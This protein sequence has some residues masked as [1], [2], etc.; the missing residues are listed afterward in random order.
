MS[1][2]DVEQP[3]NILHRPRHR[4]G[5][6]TVEGQRDHARARG[7]PQRRADSH[8]RQMRARPA[9]RIAR[10]GT[11]TRHGEA[12]RDTGGRPAARSCRRPVQRVRVRRPS[13]RRG[14]R[15]AW[16]ERPLR[17]VRLRHD[18]RTRLPQP[19]DHERVARRDDA[20]QSDRAAGRGQI[21]RVEVV[22]DQNRYAEQPSRNRSGSQS[23]VDLVRSLQRP[24]IHLG[25]GVETAR[26]VVRIDAVEV[27][28]DHVTA[29]CPS[30]EDRR[31]ERCDRRF[32]DRDPAAAPGAR[33]I[34]GGRGRFGSLRLVLRLRPVPARADPQ[35]H[36]RQHDHQQYLPHRRP[37][38]SPAHLSAWNPNPAI[39]PRDS[40]DAHRG[41]PWRHVSPGGSVPPR[42]HV[43]G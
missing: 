15:L 24:R 17:H 36:E 6:V 26:P 35:Q 11:E 37:L 28:P 12:R 21:V 42:G 9:D 20:G 8:E 10:V 43:F 32:D 29:R 33:N 27:G 23:P 31:L 1:R 40:T 16:T 39:T 30:L 7:E 4:P 3:G 34:D 5:H 19:P 14:D 41:A 22:L 2:H 25:D 38:R 13:V 18:D